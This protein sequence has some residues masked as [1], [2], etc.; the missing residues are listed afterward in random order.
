MNIIKVESLTVKYDDVCAVDNISFSIEK[1]KIFGLMG[2]NGA[3]KS[4]TLESLA[5]LKINYEGKIELFEMD[6]KKHRK[7]IQKKMGVLIQGVNYHPK[8]KVTEI[9]KYFSSFYNSCQD[10]EE[11]IKI[12]LPNHQNSLV[13]NLSAGQKQRLGIILSLINNPE[14]LILDEPSTGLDVQSRNLFWEY[15]KNISNNGTTVLIASH[16]I[17]EIECICEKVAIIDDGKLL[18][19]DTPSFLI[20]KYKKCVTNNIII[21]NLEDV[22]LHLTGKGLRD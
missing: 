20:E 10:C 5:G 16:N 6:L 8:L 19:M 3:G 9:I 4:S 15:L 1:G 17:H 14:I 18:E 11:L 13:K 12:F 21:S 2:P 7:I 22:F